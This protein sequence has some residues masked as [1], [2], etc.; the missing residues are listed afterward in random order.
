[1]NPP[2]IRDY[3]KEIHFGDDSYKIR[4]V[5]K[6]K[7]ESTMGECDP[8]EREIRIKQGLGRVDTLKTFLHELCHLLE[9][10]AP[11]TLHHETIYKLENAIFD[12]LIKNF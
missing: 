1:M 7:D 12:L 8:S 10:E 4:F 3:P 5:R 11:C 2:R 6:F 9:F